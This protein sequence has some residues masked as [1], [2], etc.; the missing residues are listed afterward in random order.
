MASV[1]TPKLDQK[2]TEMRYIC[3]RYERIGLWIGIAFVVIGAPPCWVFCAEI[4]S[5]LAVRRAR[6]LQR[7]P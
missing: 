2:S 6:Q 3:V 7:G 4:Y 5:G 1:E